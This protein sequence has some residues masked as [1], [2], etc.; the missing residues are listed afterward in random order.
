MII[1]KDAIFIA[2]A[3]YNSHR[4][5]LLTLLKK[6]VSKEIQTTQII[7]MGDIFDF[8]CDQITYFQDINYEVI[9]LINSISH[10]IEIIYLEG[11]H[12]FSLRSTFPKLNLINRKKQPIYTKLN[13]KTVAISHGDIYTPK[14]YDI[15]T[16]FFRN[17]YTLSF[18]NLIDIANWISRL[19]E[20][21]L[22][23][24]DI[25]KVQKNFKQ[26][27][28]T[29]IENYNVDLIIEGHY[30]QGY[31]DEKYINLPSLAC[32][33]QYMQYDGNE[34]KFIKV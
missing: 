3:H 10:E 33:E 26:F 30:H 19:A 24:K 8:L 21:K 23:A 27:V 1:Q 15:F 4:T 2:D 14:S 34:F 25:C 7:F 29:R 32:H 13:N 9:D 18:L 5:L 11:N 31:Q 17:S 6:I 28:N 20:K 22:K 16:S 12:D